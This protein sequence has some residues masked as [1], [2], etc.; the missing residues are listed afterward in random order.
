MCETLHL[1]TINEVVLWPCTAQAL[2]FGKALGAIGRPW[3]IHSKVEAAHLFDATVLA[4]S[5]LYVL[6]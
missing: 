5:H 4:S 2:S 6:H 3:Y 1:L